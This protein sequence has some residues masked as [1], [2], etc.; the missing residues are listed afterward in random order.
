MRGGG[1]PRAFH[2]FLSLLLLGFLSGCVTPTG[3]KSQSGLLPKPGARVQLA[4]V[5]N[6]SGATFEVDAE[7]LLREAMQTALKNGGLEWS[8]SFPGTH[9]DLKLEI[10]EYHPGNAFKRWV[11]PGWGGTVLAV[12]GE[13]K[14]PKTGEVAVSIDHAKSILW[15]G[16]FSI[17]AW[18][19][20]FGTVAEDIAEDLKIRIE[21]GG[22]FVVYL[23][24]RAEQKEVPKPPKDAGKIKIADITDQRADK[25]RIGTREAAFGVSMGE[26]HLGSHPPVAVRDALADDLT[27]GGY[28]VVESGQDLTVYGKL[29]KF[30]VRTDTTALYWDIVGEM[31]LQLVIQGAS[32]SPME[33]LYTC[34]TSDRT[35]V[36]PSAT[37]MGKVLDACLA[38]M[39]EKMRSDKVWKQ[40]LASG[41]AP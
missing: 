37:L 34:H 16:V 4:A 23:T 35:Y 7:N 17:G 11:A 39:M 21:K 6:T 2:L 29:R 3:N 12:R 20:I 14:D 15:G 5:T 19:T 26:V 31:E 36:W 40:V 30:W 1:K 9:F 24:P 13:L 32:G 28:R 25:N 41:L 10:T 33:T 38:E 18:E 22:Y 27:V 8:P